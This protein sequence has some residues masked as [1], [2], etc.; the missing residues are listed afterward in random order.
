MRPAI[1]ILALGAANRWSIAAALE[2]CNAM[3]YFVESEDQFSQADAMVLPGVA[4]FG[5]LSRAIDRKALRGPLMAAIERDVPIL[6]ICAGFQLL[7]ESSEE[8]PGIKG[9]GY[10][11]G[12]VRRLQGP[13]SP[14]MGWNRT[15][16]VPGD[17]TIETGWAYFA[18]TFAP[19]AESPDAIAHTRY[20]R[21]FTSVARRG[22]VMGMQFHPERSGGYGAG[23]LRDFVDSVRCA[24]AR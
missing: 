14:H 10:F 3:P 7:Y 18:H 9:L 17:A 15:L 12:V 16:A 6:G 24:R 2:R 23:L 20:G 1:G 21:T 11:R 5:F 13:K 19:S 8:A 22:A 4:H